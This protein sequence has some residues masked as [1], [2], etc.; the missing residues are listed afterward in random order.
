[1]DLNDE[2]IT[3]VLLGNMQDGGLPHI[4]CQCSHCSAAYRDPTLVEFAT[5]L[6]IVDKRKT[7]YSVWL[8]DATPD[9][10]WQI[11]ML[12]DVLGPHPDRKGRIRQ[13][14]GIFLTHAH[15]G[16]VGGLL[17]CGPEAMAAQKMPVYAAPE[18]ISLLRSTRLF[19]PALAGFELRPLGVGAIH[20]LAPDL[21]FVPLA[22][23]H[24]DEWGA[25]TLA[26][27]IRGPQRSLLYLPDID[28]WAKWKEAETIL[29][30]VDYALVDA[31]FYSTVELGGREP[32]AH[33][34]IPDTL[35]R[36]AALPGQLILT[37]FNHTNPVLDET[38]AARAQVI[39]SGALFG[40]RGMTFQL[41]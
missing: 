15:M 31:S 29:S 24:R 2:R 10:K 26:Y 23:P 4:A 21:T 1:M 22:V 8:I 37:H 14:D 3:A 28:A 41:G 17:Q 9:I 12:A 18:L 40:K 39:Q 33:P 35:A 16:H 7:P 19:Q 30:A 6:A 32:V 34:L 11:N 25:G 13:P 38:S 27:H 36:F 20:I 5:C